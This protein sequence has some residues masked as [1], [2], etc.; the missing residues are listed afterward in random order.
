M[1]LGRRRRREEEDNKKRETVERQKN[2]PLTHR[3]LNPSEGPE[4]VNAQEI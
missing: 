4:S 1:R 2:E 3:T